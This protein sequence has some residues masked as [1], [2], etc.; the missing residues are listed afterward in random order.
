MATGTK[1]TR[2]TM[3]PLLL[4]SVPEFQFRREAFLAKWEPEGEPLPEF[5]SIQDLTEFTINS[6]AEGEFDVVQRVMDLVDIWV[7]D[8]DSDVNDLAV[9]GFIEDLSNWAMPETAKPEDFERFMTARLKAEW[10]AMRAAWASLR[11]R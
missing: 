3:W 9:V 2:D 8:G 10:D 5:I 7:C 6:F 11:D 4:E 1:I